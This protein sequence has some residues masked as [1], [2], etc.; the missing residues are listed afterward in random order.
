MRRVSRSRPFTTRGMSKIPRKVVLAAYVTDADCS[1]TPA[2][3]FLAAD[4][5][6]DSAASF[7]EFKIRPCLSILRHRAPGP[8]PEMTRQNFTHGLTK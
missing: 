4:F 5:F 3:G 6:A 2:R 7:G 1:G 8:V